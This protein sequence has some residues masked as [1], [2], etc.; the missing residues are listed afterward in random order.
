MTIINALASLAVTDIRVAK[1]WYVRLFGR[2]PD[3]EPMPSLLE[4]Q[5][6]RGGRLQVYEL[7]ERAGKGSV[8]LAI[9]SLDEQIAALRD[10]GIAPGAPIVS[11]Q[12]RVLMIKD[13]DGNSLAFAEALDPKMA[14]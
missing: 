8:T 1:A 2:A 10:A 7:R 11:E 9:T 14:R 4:W 5:F 3:A 13:P 6:A 12:A